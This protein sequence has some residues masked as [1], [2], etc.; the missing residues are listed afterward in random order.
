MALSKQGLLIASTYIAHKYQMS[1]QDLLFDK[2]FTVGNIPFAN[3]DASDELNEAKLWGC[4][5]LLV[6]HMMELQIPREPSKT[7]KDAID[8]VFDCIKAPD[9]KYRDLCAKVDEHFHFDDE[10]DV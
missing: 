1:L 5:G 9:N 3:P 4:A 7:V 6:K 10:A 8:A 2:D